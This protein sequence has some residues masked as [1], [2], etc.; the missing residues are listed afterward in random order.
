MRQWFVI[1]MILLLPLRAW[2]GGVMLTS[3]VDQPGASLAAATVPCHPEVAPWGP[4]GHHGSDDA[5]LAEAHGSHLLC[6]ICNGPALDVQALSLPLAEPL[7]TPAPV[8]SVSFL[9]AWPARDARPPI[10]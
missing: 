8:A 4:A 5:P 7:V 3:M 9:S 6:D 10:A 1:L 2:A